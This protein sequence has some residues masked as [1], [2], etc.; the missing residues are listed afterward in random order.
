M[1]GMVGYERKFENVRELSKKKGQDD[2]KTKNFKN[3]IAAKT[4]LKVYIK[5]YFTQYFYTKAKSPLFQSSY[6]FD[7]F[8][9]FLAQRTTQVSTHKQFTFQMV[10]LKKLVLTAN[11]AFKTSHHF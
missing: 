2:S 4:P 11:N 5:N 7:C 1:N 6:C 3:N 10:F 9:T 8:L